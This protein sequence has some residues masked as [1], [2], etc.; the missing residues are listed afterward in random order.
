MTSPMFQMARVFDEVI[1]RLEQLPSP[2][3]DEQR[4]YGDEDDSEAN[5]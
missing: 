2:S 3:G 5:G 1:A 4:D